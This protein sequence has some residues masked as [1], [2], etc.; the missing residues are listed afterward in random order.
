[1]AQKLGVVI[2]GFK[3]G[4]NKALRTY[5]GLGGDRGT[6]LE[7]AGDAGSQSGIASFLKKINNRVV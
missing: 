2:R 4:C 5:L 3:Q 6:V 7:M 1:M